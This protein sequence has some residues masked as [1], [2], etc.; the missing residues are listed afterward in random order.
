[1]FHMASQSSQ[2]R[3]QSALVLIVFNFPNF[4]SETLTVMRVAVP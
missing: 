4:R 1:M 3:Q 2:V